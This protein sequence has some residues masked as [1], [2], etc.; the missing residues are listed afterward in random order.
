MNTLDLP[1]PTLDLN[2]LPSV[3]VHRHFCGHPI[4]QY[5]LELSDLVPFLSDQVPFLSDRV[6]PR[7]S[8]PV[9]G[10]YF[11]RPRLGILTYFFLCF[12]CCSS[13]LK[14]YV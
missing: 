2:P 5:I 12:S 6:P 3:F 9:K 14:N 11:E 8:L 4:R 13:I 10:R 1:M 7:H